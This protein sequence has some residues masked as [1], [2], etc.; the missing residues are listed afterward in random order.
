M[1]QLALAPLTATAFAPFGQV[2]EKI[3]AENF[4]INDG[5]ATRFHDLAAIETTAENGKTLVNIFHGAPRPEPVKITMLER[6]NLG[7]QAFMPLGPC[8]WAV[9]VA[10]PGPFAA[11]ALRGFLVGPGQGVNYNPGTWHHPLMVFDQ[12][13]DF[14]V[15]DRGGAAI[16]CEIIA[17]SPHILGSARP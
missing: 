15:I 5:L 13:T 8:R 10:P 9:V 14:L 2:I 12:D 3:G 11:S 4:A 7:S 6:H 16:D 17:V 1:K